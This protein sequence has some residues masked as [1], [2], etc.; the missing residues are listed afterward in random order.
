MYVGEFLNC[1][2]VAL[3]KYGMSPNQSSAVK[4]G[5]VLADPQPQPRATPALE[6]IAIELH[7][8]VEHPRLILH[9]DPFR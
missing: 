8:L 1:T 5:Q 3:F 9:S 7:E 4:G 2:T 6:G